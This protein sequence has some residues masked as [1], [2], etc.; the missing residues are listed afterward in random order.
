MTAKELFIITTVI[1]ASMFSAGVSLINK[2]MPEVE[3][4]R[5]CAYNRVFVEFKEGNTVWGTMLLDWEGKPIQCH[6]EGNPFEEHTTYNNR[7][8]I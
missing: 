3:A 1:C 2:L 7:I 4:K 5:F 6:E 8:S